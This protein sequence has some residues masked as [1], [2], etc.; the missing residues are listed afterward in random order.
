VLDRITRVAGYF[1]LEFGGGDENGQS[2]GLPGG[3]G[4]F[5]FGAAGQIAYIALTVI[6]TIIPIGKLFMA[7]KAILKMGIKAALTRML[8]RLRALFPA[9]KGVLGR[10][11]PTRNVILQANK[12]MRMLPWTKEFGKVTQ[13]GFGR[14]IRDLPRGHEYRRKLARMIREIR[15]SG[16]AAQVKDLGPGMVAQHIAAGT[17]SVFQYNPAKLR[18]VDFIEEA[19][20]WQQISAG[21]HMRGYSIATLEI[22]AKQ[23]VLR[24]PG[25]SPALRAE[26]RYDIL[27]ILGGS[28][29]YGP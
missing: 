7:G 1:D 13:E 28:Y 22:L 17:T 9:A 15:R 26:F 5:N 14:L 21:L 18:I 24:L 27:R 11:L 2:G 23:K 16:G 29:T 25:L 4:F 8:I 12:S 19:V 3:M 6:T 10:I 20:H